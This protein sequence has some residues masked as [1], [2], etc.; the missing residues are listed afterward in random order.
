MIF[1]RVFPV[2]CLLLYMCFCAI[3][4]CRQCWLSCMLPR[5]EFSEA[6]AALERGDKVRRHGWMPGAVIFSPAGE[7][8]LP[9]RKEVVNQPAYGSEF[10]SFALADLTA[11]DWEI[12]VPKPGEQS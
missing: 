9:I 10:F 2:A 5:M 7:S 6:I 11:T 3:A 8:E 4:I 12:H 1:F